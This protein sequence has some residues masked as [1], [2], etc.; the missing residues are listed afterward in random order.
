MSE[1]P[2]EDLPHDEDSPYNSLTRLPSEHNMNVQ[3]QR[4]EEEQAQAAFMQDVGKEGFE[5]SSKEQSRFLEPGDLVELSFPSSERESTMA[6]FVQRVTQG[7]G[8][9]LALNGRW[10]HLKQTAVPYSISG[11]IDPKDLEPVLK[12]LPNP[13]TVAELEALRVQAYTEDLDV[14]R[15]ITGPLIARLQAFTD[16]VQEIY[17]RNASALDDAHNILAHETDLRYGSLAS[18]ATALL[19][20]PADKMPL[21][22]LF[23]VRKALANGGFAFNID[24]R[25]H[26]L[27]GY[28]QIRSKE[29]VRMVE[30]VRDWI[31]QWQD[32][33]ALRASMDE[34]RR[35]RHKPS[36]GAEIMYG[37]IEKSR[38]IIAKQRTNRDPVPEAG[39]VGPS[40]MRFPITSQSDYFRVQTEGQF[41]EQDADIVKFMEGWCCSNLYAGLPRLQSL[42]PL[43]LNAL[44]LYPDVE[45]LQ[46]IG[47]LF[48][49]ELGTIMPYEN[50]VRFDQH[51]LLPSSQHSKPLQN[52]MSS[53]LGMRD[54]HGLRDSM[55]DLRHDWKEL[56]VYCIDDA[57]AQEIDDGISIENAGVDS[58]GK[59]LHWLH[60]HVANPT[61]YFSRDHPLAK[62]ARH[63]GETIYMPERAYM[64]LPRWATKSLFSLAPNRPCLT[65]SAKLNSDGESVDQQVTSGMIRNVMRITYDELEDQVL[66]KNHQAA[67]RVILTVGGTP[68]PD[69]FPS[70]SAS[71]LTEQNRNELRRI[72]DLAQARS[73]ARKRAGGIFFEVEQP[74]MGVWQNARKTGL[75]WDHPW[76]HGSRSVYGDPIIQLQTQRLKNWFTASRSQAQVLVSEA[77]LL[78]SEIAAT[79]CAKRRIPAIYRGTTRMSDTV[80][81]PRKGEWEELLAQGKQLPMYLGLPYLQSMGYTVLRTHPL[82]HNY[83]G[84]DHYAK[85]TS[86]LR[87][88]GDM[89]LHWQ[90][91]AALRYE[92]TT[93]QTLAVGDDDKTK[94]DRSF[95]PFSNQILETI[96]LGLQ[97]RETMITRAKRYSISHWISMLLFRMHHFKEGGAGPVPDPSSPDFNS[98]PGA[99]PPGQG[100]LP[101]KTLHC[102]PEA[103]QGDIWEVEMEA[104]NIYSRMVLVRPLR[105][106]EREAM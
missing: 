103:R 53:L 4:S 26:R 9:Y 69:R 50:R 2:Q 67:E 15:D 18:A 90:I 14:P 81:H 42:P 37:F 88:Y 65:F 80:E 48:L 62:M 36:K 98:F 84:M 3:S 97:P 64:M 38:Q 31:R 92:A 45:L 25:S 102:F 43:I 60:V 72:M 27:T 20:L 59:P 52:L 94:H 33:L 1:L 34:H 11:W 71:S 12:H 58:Q 5:G 30:K 96:M 17:R 24:R 19:K 23:T 55:S 35:G 82:K 73:A 76:R 57:S 8:Q 100:G 40:K 75:G 61:A 32:D 51:L 87:R 68:P 16:E 77:M 44:E 79:Y 93:G 49:Q 66:G 63:M 89:I 83:L 86:P 41:T 29:Q 56:P 78:C 21:P 74:Y 99:L 28:M 6:I 105:L 39:N 54:N 10:L 70:S 91:E 46:S 22:A 104:V 101:F 95:L 47:F 13:K 106:V 7:Y 85:V